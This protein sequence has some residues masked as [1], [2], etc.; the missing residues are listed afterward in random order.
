MTRRTFL[1]LVSSVKVV[2]KSVTKFSSAAEKWYRVDVGKELTG[3]NTLFLGMGSVKERWMC[4]YKQFN[5]WD[6]IQKKHHTFFDKHFSNINAKQN[7]FLFTED[8]MKLALTSDE[9][10]F[11]CKKD[12]FALVKHAIFDCSNSDWQ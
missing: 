5:W 7:R 8:N 11:T 6:V 2:N 4:W 1:F 9:M 12:V 3:L 10:P